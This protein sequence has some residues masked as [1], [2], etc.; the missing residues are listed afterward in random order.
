MICHYRSGSRARIAAAHDNVKRHVV[1][2]MVATRGFSRRYVMMMRRALDI[3]MH[4]KMTGFSIAQA[5][6]WHHGDF[7]FALGW[8]AMGKI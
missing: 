6:R 4:R 2:N 1:N 3:S 7:L 8:P 5:F